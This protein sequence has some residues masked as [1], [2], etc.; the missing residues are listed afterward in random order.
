MEELIRAILRKNKGTGRKT[1][2]IKMTATTL[3]II[4]AV[5]IKLSHLIINDKSEDGE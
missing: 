4:F 5:A 2:Q 3:A 1:K